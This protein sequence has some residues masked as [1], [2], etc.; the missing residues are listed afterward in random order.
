MST[1]SV[2]S[3]TE[4]LGIPSVPDINSPHAPA[5]GYA[6]LDITMD[7]DMYRAST[8]RAFLPPSLTQARKSRLFIC[9][10]T[11]ATRLELSISPTEKIR[12]LGVHFQAIKPTA[13]ANQSFYVKAKREVI[14]CCGALGSPHIMQLR[15]VYGIFKVCEWTNQSLVVVWD[16]KP[17]FLPRGS[18]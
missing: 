8:Y 14:L 12:V 17:I 15:S 4:S 3:A 16:P 9:T 11:H 6:T 5:A 2:R 1:I 13:V 18:T 10:N 7:K